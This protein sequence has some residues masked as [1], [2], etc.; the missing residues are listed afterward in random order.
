MSGKLS[1]KE[2][3]AHQ[4][5]VKE[6]SRAPSVSPVE[7][8]KARFV[9]FAP[10]IDQPVQIA[11]VLRNLGM[12]LK[13]AHGALNRLA[14]KEVVIVQ[15]DA[16]NR[17]AIAAQLAALGLE[18]TPMA[19]PMPDIKKIREKFGV[20]QSEFATQFGLELDT[21][22]NWEQ[23]RNQ[24]DPTARLLLKIIELYP[25]V[26]ETVLIG[27]QMSERTGRSKT[28]IWRQMWSTHK[29]DSRWT[30]VKTNVPVQPYG[31]FVEPW[32][33]AASIAAPN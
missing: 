10:K 12:S 8:E 7:A 22:Q 3:L 26:V 21:L 20:S 25:T 23:G 24:L 30:Y 9:L 16:G 19:P 31:H 6:G 28:D 18:A 13:K 29:Y 17:D 33:V 11:R 1:F 5:D 2:A 15:L 27:Q 14:N 4:V 32:T